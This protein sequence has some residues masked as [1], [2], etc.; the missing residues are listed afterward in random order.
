[1]T[2]IPFLHQ[3]GYV[4]GAWIGADS[5]ATCDV[6][7]PATGEIIGTVPNMGRSETASAIAAAQA[8]LPDWSARTAEER[9]DILMRLYTLLLVHQDELALLMT[10][11][12]GKPLAEAKGEILYGASF[13]RWF[14]EQARRV[15]G[16]TI[17]GHQRDK[18]IITIRQPIGVV[19]AIT[20][21]NFPNAMIARKMGPALAAGCTFVCKPALQTP[22]SALAM[23]DLCQQAGVPAGVFNIVTGDARE[24]GAEMTANPI[25]RKITFT[26]STGIGKLLMQQCAATMKRISLELGGNAPFLVFDD[27]D[28]DAAVEGAMV[29]KF[30]NSGQTCVCT[31]RIYV[32]SGVHDVF[33]EKLAAAMQGLRVGNGAEAGINQGPLIDDNAVT[34]VETLVADAVGKGGRVVQGGKRHAL[35]GTWFEPTLITGAAQGMQIARDETFGPVAPVFRFDTEDEGIAMANATE[36]GLAAYFYAQDVQRCFRVAEKLESGMVGV[37]TGL[38]STTVAP[39]GGIKESGFGREGSHEG[40][41]EYLETKYVCFGG[42]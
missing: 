32:Q 26:G 1:M 34:K 33:V 13:I 8:A 29:S 11:E 42:V 23:A 36:F 10:L 25:V 3:Q 17:P 5:G 37:N 31:N 14:A 40:M 21:W 12:Q 38:I 15:Y 2:R 18:R 28:L 30:R 27:A 22:F 39:F 41:D 9:A 4:D 20:P 35:G 16:D 6:V 19:G 24:I 7:N